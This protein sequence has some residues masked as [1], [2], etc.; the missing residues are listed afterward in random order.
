MV[1]KALAILQEGKNLVLYSALGPDD[2]AIR[3]TAERLQA[4]S[5][6]PTMAGED[7]AFNREKFSVDCSKVRGFVGFVLRVAIPV[8][9]QFNS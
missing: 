7:L 5:I 8:G 3:V 1:H 9:I 6:D 4:I 2:P